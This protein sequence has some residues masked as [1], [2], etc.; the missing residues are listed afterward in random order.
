MS[1]LTA[2]ARKVLIIR[3]SSMG[4]VV[5]TSPVVRSLKQARPE[6]QIHFLTKVAY[7]PLVEHSPYVDRVH[8]LG[9]HFS[10]LLTQLK[11]EQFDYIIDLHRNL[12]SLRIKLAL[13]KPSVAF[14]KQNLRKWWMVRSK[15]TQPEIGHIVDR[16]ADTL[17]G[18]D[19]S[20]DD[21]GLELFLP[22][23]LD[24]FGEQIVSENQLNRPLAVVLGA[25]HATKRWLPKH[26]VAALNELG[27]DV[28]L[29]GGK[30]MKTEAQFISEHL[31]VRHLNG[32]G[33]YS[34]LESAALLKACPNVL[35]HDTGLMHIAAAFKIPSVVLWGNTVPAFG[36][37]PFRSPHKNLEASRPRHT[38]RKAWRCAPDL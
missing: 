18:F 4:D 30:D 31:H 34:M 16:Y 27:R 37:Y 21:K 22:P 2:S 33:E 24:G 29:L 5:L 6:V 7:A 1:S 20:L 25:T 38:T 15:K 13:K 26:F 14:D 19:L 23:E 11:A 10:E 32:V 35:T 9:D 3:F 36:M 17:K 12:R 28:V 8:C